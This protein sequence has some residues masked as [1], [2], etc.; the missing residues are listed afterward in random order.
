MPESDVATAASAAQSP[1]ETVLERLPPDQRINGPRSPG[2]S[3]RF[4]V[5][6]IERL[7][8][9][10]WIPIVIVSSEAGSLRSF[11]SRFDRPQG[12]RLDLILAAA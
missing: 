11:S 9:L 10:T 6:V 7:L 2:A 5:L 4:R 3:I 8:S 12:Q 1:R